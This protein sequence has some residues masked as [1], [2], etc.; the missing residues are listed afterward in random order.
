[1]GNKILAV[2]AI[3]AVSMIVAGFLVGGRYEVISVSG[4]QSDLG[5]VVIVDRFSGSAKQCKLQ[6]ASCTQI[7]EPNSN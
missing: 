6:Y 2:A 3:I 7:K 4:S 1:M 5:H